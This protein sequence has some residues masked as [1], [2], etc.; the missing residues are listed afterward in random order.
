MPARTLVAV[1]LAIGM[2][3]GLT[4]VLCSAAPPSDATNS[5]PVAKTE[6]KPEKKE[7]K[8]LTGSELY[9]IN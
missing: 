8:K 6:P 7:V 9:A 5:P 1:C 2:V 3:F 4:M